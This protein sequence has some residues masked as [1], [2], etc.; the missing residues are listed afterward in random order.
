MFL[1]APTSVMHWNADTATWFLQ[2]GVG[3]QKWIHCAAKTREV[4]H[5]LHIE[6]KGSGWKIISTGRREYRLNTFL[7][8]CMETLRRPEGA[9][10]PC[11]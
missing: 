5:A 8:T 11:G 7:R 1:A 6:T 4:T 2:S 10:K 3:K 9:A